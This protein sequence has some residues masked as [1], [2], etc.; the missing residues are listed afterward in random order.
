MILS[1]DYEQIH[2]GWQKYT[3]QNE[4]TFVTQIHSFKVGANLELHDLNFFS[5]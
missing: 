5:L 1:E 4:H 3:N 2:L